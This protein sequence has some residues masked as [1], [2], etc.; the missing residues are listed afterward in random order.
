MRNFNVTVNGKAYSVQVEEGGVVSAPAQ[1]AAPVAAAPVAAPVAAAP[2]A[3][4]NGTRMEAPMPGMIIDYK[5]ANGT[6]VKKG[7]VVLILEAMKMENDI[8]APCDGVFT[9]ASTKGTTVATGD[10]LATIA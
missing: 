7:D 9:A 2:A 5:V 8:T 10:L 3:P 1:A 6:A 4:S